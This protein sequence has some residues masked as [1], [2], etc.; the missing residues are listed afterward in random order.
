MTFWKIVAATSKAVGAVFT[1]TKAISFDGST[2]YM[3]NTTVQNIGIANAFTFSV[4]LK[5]LSFPAAAPLYRF[6]LVLSPLVGT[7][8]N[9]GIYNLSSSSKIS[10]QIF[11][12]TGV[13][14]KDYMLTTAETVGVKTMFTFSWDGTNMKVYSDGTE[15]TT[16]TKNS[17]NAGTMTSTNR[18]VWIGSSRGTNMANVEISKANVWS[19]VLTA[20]EITSL[21]GGGTGY[22]SDYTTN[23]GSYVSAAN[24]QHDWNLGR[25]AS[26]SLGQ[27]RGATPINVETNSANITDADIVTF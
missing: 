11:D 19:S 9:I 5:F 6:I 26:P 4:W 1:Q 7:I 23:F 3:A 10:V 8:N 15:D 20:A 18:G 12:S 16:V 22:Q 14:I 21:Y 25:L 2:E 27:D 17:D 24:C 13:N